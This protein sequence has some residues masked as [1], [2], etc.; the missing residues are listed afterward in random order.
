MESVNG[1]TVTRVDTLKWVSYETRP[2]GGSTPS[3]C[4]AQGEIYFLS[5][6][7]DWLARDNPKTE[8][9]TSDGSRIAEASMG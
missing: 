1:V 8:F 3:S 2:A 9:K 6:A 4:T 5:V 7:I